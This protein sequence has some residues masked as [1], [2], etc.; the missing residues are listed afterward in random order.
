M[1]ES[2]ACHLLWFK[3]LYFIYLLHTY[4]TEIVVYTIATVVNNILCYLITGKCFLAT[5]ALI[6][7]NG[8][9]FCIIKLNVFLRKKYSLNEWGAALIKL[10]LKSIYRLQNFLLSSKIV[11]R[12]LITVAEQKVLFPSSFSSPLLLALPT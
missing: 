2:F 5:T 12:L 8:K 3:H 10:K 4:K 1:E 11:Y 9:R 6:L 7:I